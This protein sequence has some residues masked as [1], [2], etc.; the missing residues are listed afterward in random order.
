LL[1]FDSSGTDPSDWA[2]SAQGDAFD[3][4]VPQDTKVTESPTDLRLLNVLGFNVSALSQPSF[5]VDNLTTGAQS[6]VAGSTYTGSMPGVTGEFI[7]VTPASLLIGSS[8]PNVF[9]YAGGGNNNIW[10]QNNT[11]TNVLDGG[12]SS[13]LLTGGSGQNQFFVDDIDTNA[14]SPLIWDTVDNFHAGDQVVVWGVTQAD[15]NLTWIPDKGNP[16]YQGLTLEATAPGKP[17]VFV[18]IAGYSPAD[19]TNGRLSLGF[20]GAGTASP[21]VYIQGH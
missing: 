14:S 11:G 18:D 16:G 7:S 13:D 2:S 3:A 9:I 15:F 6:T 4:F 19:L 8:T 21:F 1:P 5:T 17:Q 12:T 10:L 20:T